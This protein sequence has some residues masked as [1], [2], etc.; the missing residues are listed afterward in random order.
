MAHKVTGGQLQANDVIRPV[1]SEN[2]TRYL[3]NRRNDNHC[4]ECTLLEG[5]GDPSITVQKDQQVFRYEG[6]PPGEPVKNYTRRGPT[7][8]RRRAF[9]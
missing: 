6:D 4:W 7:S 9:Q 3:V 1:G 2:A 8:C 5:D